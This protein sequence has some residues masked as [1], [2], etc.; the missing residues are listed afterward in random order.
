MGRAVIVK[1]DE[2]AF[3]FLL[4]SLH[5][6]RR[7]CCASHINMST[8]GK[9][10]FF[11]RRVVWVCGWVLKDI[12]I[13]IKHFV[14]FRAR[15]SQRPFF[16]S[17]AAHVERLDPLVL[18]DDTDVYPHWWLLVLGAIAGWLEIWI[19]HARLPH[20]LLHGQE[21]HP[22]ETC[23]SLHPVLRQALRRWGFVKGRT[24]MLADLLTL[25]R[26]AHK[27]CWKQML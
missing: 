2:N 27:S 10:L 9:H 18:L 11:L 19:L 16:L 25:S 3:T 15:Q 7:S 23:F 4:G 8:W 5:P 1:W 24:S 12:L 17:P 13:N 20:A 26:G 22:D 21:D 6:G 14:P